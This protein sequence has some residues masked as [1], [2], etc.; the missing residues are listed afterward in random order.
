MPI[1]RRRKI[2]RPLLAMGLLLA[3]CWVPAFQPTALARDPSPRIHKSALSLAVTISAD[4]RRLLIRIRRGK[5]LNG[6]NRA[7]TLNRVVRMLLGGVRKALRN[8]FSR[9]FRARSPARGP[10]PR[11]QPLRRAG[12]SSEAAELAL[13]DFRSALSRSTRLSQTPERLE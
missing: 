1:P 12:S 4:T 5:R 13:A 6:G 10:E 8:R 7:S 9:I 2:G 11:G 3:V